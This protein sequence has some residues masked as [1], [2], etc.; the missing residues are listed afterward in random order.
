[1]SPKEEIK[2][3]PSKN[4]ITGLINVTGE[5]D[6]GK[7]SF[8]L[9]SGAAPERTAFIDDDVK[10]GS[11]VKEVIASGHKFG[12]YRDLVKEAEGL[13]EIDFHNLCLQIIHDLEAMKGNLDVIVWDTWTKF[14][15]TFQPVVVSSPL[16]FRQYYSAMGQIKGAEQW[17]ASFDYEAIVLA[18]LV[19]IAPLVI[20]TSHL[21]KDQTRVRDIAESKKPLVQKSRM[22]VWL[23]HNP[24]APQPIGLMLKRLLKMTV[25]DE[26]M[27]PVNVTHRKVKPLTWKRLIHFWEN[28]VGDNPPT[29]EERLSEYELSILDG[30]LTRDQKEALKLAVIEAEKEREQEKAIEEAAR[31]DPRPQDGIKFIGRVKSEFG[32]DLKQV[33]DILGIPF[34]QINKEYKV[35]FW[36]TIKAHIEEGK[37]NEKQP[38]P[39]KEKRSKK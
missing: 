33:Q 25:T 26:G 16:R 32:L 20:V 38:E 36:D 13:R 15:N 37:Q 22:R 28:P 21:K 17:Q 39:A 23:R 11:T 14:E 9:S 3:K 30:V 6:T 18:K 29:A 12:Y 35:E 7:T 19:N 2:I 5:P 24:D 31:N 1:M 4:P 34:A 10:G 27:V 8:A